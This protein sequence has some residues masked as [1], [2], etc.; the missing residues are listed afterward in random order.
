MGPSLGDSLQA[1]HP[2]PTA[3]EVAA[4][5]C[6]ISSPFELLSRAERQVTHALLTRAPL[7]SR[8]EGRF[9]ARLACVK[10]AAN[11]R[12]EPGSNSPIEMFEPLSNLRFDRVLVCSFPCFSLFSFQGPN[13]FADS[14]FSSARGGQSIS[15]FQPVKLFFALFAETRLIRGTTAATGE[16]LYS[17]QRRGQG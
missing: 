10:P 17:H 2:F 3:T 7:Y 6:G 1:S 16:G 11:V 13:L 9:L 8:P 4:D 15:L 12:S 14:D 5:V